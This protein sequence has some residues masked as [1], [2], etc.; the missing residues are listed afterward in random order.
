[1]ARIPCFV[2][3]LGSAKRDDKSGLPQLDP[4]EAKISTPSAKTLV[5]KTE[6]ILHHS[7]LNT[8]LSTW[9]D[10]HVLWRH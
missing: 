7:M 6:L 2:E 8:A 9:R 4:L 10:P 5:H 1:M 3:A